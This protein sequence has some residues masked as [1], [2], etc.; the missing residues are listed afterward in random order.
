MLEDCGGLIG[1][2]AVAHRFAVLVGEVEVFEAAEAGG[3]AS[4]VGTTP[5]PPEA[6][7]AAA[8]E[9]R[10]TA[11]M[12]IACKQETGLV[13]IW[14]EAEAA[15]QRTLIQQNATAFDGVLTE[16]RRMLGEADAVLARPAPG[17]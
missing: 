1:A 9:E 3:V 17:P 5:A 2:T 12:D 8:A 10:T 13:R 4:R 14:N 6:A 15:V 11:L 7:P 16:R